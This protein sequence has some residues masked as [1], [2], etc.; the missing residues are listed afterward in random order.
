M[1]SHPLLQ[2][3]VEGDGEPDERIDLFQMVRKGEPNPCTFV[4]DENGF[5]SDDVLKVVTVD[6]NSRDALEASWKEAFNRDLDDGSWCN[7]ENWSI[8]EGG[9]SSSP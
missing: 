2:S 9:V 3:H 7:V 4:V 1:A 8:V 6:G 5:N